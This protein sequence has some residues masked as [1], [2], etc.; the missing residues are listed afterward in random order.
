[1]ETGRIPESDSAET[2][3]CSTYNSAERGR[4]EFRLMAA[5]ISQLRRTFE[6]WPAPSPPPWLRRFTPYTYQIFLLGL[7]PLAFYLD[8]HTQSIAQQNILGVCAWII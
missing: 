8:I 2:W 6:P 5:R 1:A 4:T 7:I 3:Y